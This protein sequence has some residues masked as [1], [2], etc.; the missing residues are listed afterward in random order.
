MYEAFRVLGPRLL[1][2]ALT[3]GE[4]LVGPTLMDI[5]GGEHRDT[6]LSFGDGGPSGRG[7]RG[8]TAGP[9][10][11]RVGEPFSLS[12]GVDLLSRPSTTLTWYHHQ[13]PAEA[14]FSQKAIDI[15]SSGDVTT[16]VTFSE[17]GDYVFRA[18]ALDGTCQ[19]E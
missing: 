12:I 8:P 15:G 1:E 17:P 3:L 13:G 10:A 9:L 4:H 11:A 2:S 16:T 6:A 18:T 5:G 7:R 14:S 19:Q